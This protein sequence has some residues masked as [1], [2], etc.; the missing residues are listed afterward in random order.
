MSEL[1]ELIKNVSDTAWWTAAGRFLES[2]RDDALFKDPLAGLLIESRAQLLESYA[3]VQ[4]LTLTMAV[5][6]K[7]IDDLVMDLIKTKNVDAVVNLAC[8]LCTRAY[9]LPLPQSIHW[10]E[11][12]FAPMIQFKQEKLSPIAAPCE[13]EF[14]AV[15]LRQAQALQDLLRE[16]SAR[17]KNVLVITEGLL[18]YLK[19]EN[20]INMA[21]EFLAHD[22]RYW[23]SDFY[24][25]PAQALA[26]NP[27]YYQAMEKADAM[28]HFDPENGLGF[29][30]DHGWIL[31]EQF[32]F[33][34]E[35]KRL[36]RLPVPDAESEAAGA[37]F[38][39]SAY[40]VLAASK[41]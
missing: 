32:N 22:V 19:E 13:L 20:V 25:H 26:K 1:P 5:R 23:L 27:Q 35:A 37:R 6:T 17:H 10:V 3:P 40:I 4:H 8:G 15:D 33:L 16:I 14:R 2:K 30:A 12:D 11:V 31:K 38:T 18:L 29:F 21:Q 36:N 41:A 34:E 7:L 28:F 39:D 9:R 24:L